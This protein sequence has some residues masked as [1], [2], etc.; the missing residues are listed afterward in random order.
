[1][2]EKWTKWSDADIE[3]VTHYYASLQ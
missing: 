1:M 2:A 3:A